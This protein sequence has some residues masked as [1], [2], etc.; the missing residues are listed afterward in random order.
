MQSLT[1]RIRAELDTP[2]SPDEI[3]SRIAQMLSPDYER[4]EK[5][6]RYAVRVAMDRERCVY[7]L[8]RILQGR[9]AAQAKA[10]EALG[11]MG[12][13]QDSVERLIEMGEPRASLL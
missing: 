8:G 11:K 7:H 6:I 4:A 9:P 12:Y 2:G 10:V 5:G 1:Q 13:S 3:A